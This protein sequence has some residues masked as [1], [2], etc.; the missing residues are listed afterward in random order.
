MRSLRHARP[1]AVSGFLRAR[2]MAQGV[3][4]TELHVEYY[5]YD[6]MAVELGPHIYVM[7]H[8]TAQLPQIP[9]R[10]F[11]LVSFCDLSHQPRFITVYQ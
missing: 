6:P 4:T 11:Q 2:S 10:H 5:A 1:C 3:G 9:E 8:S 7:R